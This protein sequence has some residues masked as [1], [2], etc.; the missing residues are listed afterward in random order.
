MRVAGQQVASLHTVS[1]VQLYQFSANDLMDLSWRRELSET[2]TAGV[3]V[4]TRLV[5]DITPWLHW[6][7]VW[8]GDALQWTGP[9]QTVTYSRETTAIA[10]ADISALMSR[11]RVPLT[12]QWEATDPAII[13]AELWRSMLEAQRI[14]GAPVVRRDP[15]V[16]VFDF[17]CRA[18]AQMLDKL[19]DDLV[20]LG[21]TWSVMAGT[22]LLG[23][24][25]RSAIAALGEDDFI[26]GN[27][28]LVRDGSRVFT[29]V[30][31]RAADD[32][33]R[34][35]VNNGGLNLQTIVDID[36]L[37]GV[38]NADRAA[39]QYLRY[40]SSMREAARLD[41]STRLHPAAPVTIASLV[42]SVRVTVAAY[43]RLTPMEVQSVEV[44]QTSDDTTVAVGLESIED[45]PPELIKTERPNG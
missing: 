30:L 14:N 1:G 2:S 35:R 29:D 25:P 45:S 23:P 32:Q 31:V 5:E 16:D 43:G 34:A 3:T 40:T 27:L 12:K 42:P 15:L 11:T 28:T 26:D 44:S 24:A 21:L 9:V 7:S 13:A 19:M 39:R 38:S 37:F 36:S 4:P 17:D 6:L 8:D 33:T 20:G 41:G 18:D 10:A 22:V